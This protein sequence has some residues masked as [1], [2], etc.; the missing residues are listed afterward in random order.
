MSFPTNRFNPFISVKVVTKTQQSVLLEGLQTWLNLGLIEDGRVS[1]HV[2]AINAE[3]VKGPSPLELEATLHPATQ[4]FLA[5]LDA[6][7]QLG[8]LVQAQMSVEIQVYKSA[9]NLLEGLDAWLQLGLL[10]QREVLQICH[11]NLAC[12]LAQ[13]EPQVKPEAVR[14]PPIA[15]KAAPESVQHGI[16]TP[17]N[18]RFADEHPSLPASQHLPVAHRPPTPRPRS[19]SPLSQILQSLAAELSVLWLLLLGVFMVVISSAVLAAS[20]WERFPAFIQYGI[21]WFYTLVFWGSSVWAGQHPN[22]RLTTQAL[23]IITLLLVPLNFLAID[24]FGLWRLPLDWCVVLIAVASLTGLTMKIFQARSTD[25]VSRLKANI[26]LLNHLGL[27]Y[28]HLIWSIGGLFPILATYVAVVGTTV[29]SRY[30]QSQPYVPPAGN[31]SPSHSQ[32]F[33]LNGA[34]LLYAVAI[35][36]LR[37]IFISRI[38]AIQLGLAIGICGWL[39]IQQAPPGRRRLQ[40]TPCP[41]RLGTVGG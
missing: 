13:I 4:D 12:W 18:Q 20:Q 28:I 1:L 22:L 9:P 10:S 14:H 15:P 6:W 3:P 33:S 37:A 26:P 21:L 17:A 30:P 36:L 34:V 5:G 23:R 27:S 32:P 31:A 25:P 38:S 19:F 2:N 24:L 7:L 29:L 41:Q 40:T 8:L 16:S 11:T 35:V 39:L